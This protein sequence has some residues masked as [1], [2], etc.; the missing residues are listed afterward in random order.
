MKMDFMNLICL[1]FARKEICCRKFGVISVF[2]AKLQVFYLLFYLLII[3]KESMKLC[4][5]LLFGE[6]WG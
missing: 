3:S 6:F 1:S 2:A 4:D 5:A